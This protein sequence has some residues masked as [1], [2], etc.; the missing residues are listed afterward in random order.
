MRTDLLLLP[1]VVEATLRLSWH[2]GRSQAWVLSSHLAGSEG[3]GV[4]GGF[5]ESIFLLWWMQDGLS[6]ALAV[7]GHKR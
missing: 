2:V 5:A 1:L 7:M 4:D 6:A 3:S